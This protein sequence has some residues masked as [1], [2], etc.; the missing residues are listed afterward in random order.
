MM[1]SRDGNN[2]RRTLQHADVR[3]LAHIDGLIQRI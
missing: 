1:G 2:G 3:T